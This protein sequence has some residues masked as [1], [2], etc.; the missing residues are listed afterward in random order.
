MMDSKLWHDSSSTL[1]H[2]ERERER[3]C[4]LRIFMILRLGDFMVSGLDEYELL[5]EGGYGD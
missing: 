5:H 3:I 1:V 4:R 2:G